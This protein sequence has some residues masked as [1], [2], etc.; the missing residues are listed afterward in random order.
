MCFAEIAKLYHKISVFTLQKKSSK[1]ISTF[2][3]VQVSENSGAFSV[4][5]NITQE[6]SLHCGV[7][8]G[9]CPNFTPVLAKLYPKLWGNDELLNFFSFVWTN[10][11]ELKPFLEMVR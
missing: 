1:R 3:A 2:H 7:M 8:M 11:S 10:Y 6:K 4:W 9:H 5:P